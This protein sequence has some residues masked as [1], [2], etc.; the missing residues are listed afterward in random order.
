VDHHFKHVQEHKE[1]VWNNLF[2][3]TGIAVM[4][5]SHPE[6]QNRFSIT[7]QD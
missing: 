5:K 3:D 6:K 2:Q 1:K 7:K 4:K